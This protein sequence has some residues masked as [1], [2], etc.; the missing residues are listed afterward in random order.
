MKSKINKKGKVEGRGMINLGKELP[1]EELGEIAETAVRLPRIPRRIPFPSRGSCMNIWKQDPLVEALGSRR[2]YLHTHTTQGP[3]DS[4]IIIKGLPPVYPDFKGDFLFETTSEKEFDAVHTY[5]VVR[6]VLTMYQRALREKMSWHW[7]DQTPISVEPRAGETPNAYYSRTSKCMKFFYFKKAGST[8]DDPYVY[9]C[10]S[11]D[12][13]AHE[14]GHAILD[15]LKPGW[16]PFSEAQT[17]GLHESFGDLT[18]IF[19]ALNQLD[20]VEYV[21]A[22][23]K[24]NLHKSNILD[25]VAEQFGNTI[26]RPSGL[27]NAD[28]DKKLSDVSNEVHDLSQVF[29]GAIY[30]I[31]AAA[32]HAARRPR[33]IDDAV[34]LYEVSKK[35]MTLT[36]EGIRLAPEQNATYKDVAEKMIEFAQS[37]PE[38]FDGYDTIITDEFSQR[39]VLGTSAVTTLVQPFEG[40]GL[41]YGTCCG[42]MH[43]L[44]DVEEATQ[45]F[46]PLREVG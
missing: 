45:E 5:A 36:L 23:T 44:A 3:K 6:M 46:G 40:L 20:L 42:T 18:A 26:G 11:L 32:F 22:N 30:D 38:E 16:L 15:G 28:N 33:W 19:M 34:M 1:V 24:G 37:H 14:T 9:T 17:G 41:N 25:K 10:R 7:G 13:V 35:V 4:Q 2:V 21:I 43:H 29:T 27:R 31:L 12:I 39:E 8:A